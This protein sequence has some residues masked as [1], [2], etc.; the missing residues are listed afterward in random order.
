[1]WKSFQ[2]I[3]SFMPST[4]QI[5][6]DE[7]IRVIKAARR[8][9]AEAL[10]R[11]T[12]ALETGL[13]NPKEWFWKNP[14]PF[15]KDPFH[16]LRGDNLLECCDLE[17][18][19]FWARLLLD[20]KSLI[21]SFFDGINVKW[22]AFALDEI[23][24]GATRRRARDLGLKDSVVF[25]THPE[26]PH[27]KGFKYSISKPFL[28]A[29][30]A[31]LRNG[32]VNARVAKE[33]KV[34]Q[35][36]IGFCV[37]Q[38]KISAQFGQLNFIHVDNEGVDFLTDEGAGDCSAEALRSL[39]RQIRNDTPET[40]L[41]DAYLLGFKHLIEPNARIECHLAAMTLFH[42]LTNHEAHA[43]AHL[44]FGF[45]VPPTRE[46]ALLIYNCLQIALSG[47]PAVYSSMCR[48]RQ[49]AAGL[50]RYKQMVQ[51][52]EP[53]LKRISGVLGQMQS[54][55]QELRAVLY[56]PEE[57]LFA[58]YSLVEPYFRNGSSVRF[59][60][61]AL[62]PI[63]L[64]HSPSLYDTYEVQL[65]AAVVLC[66]V[67]GE[68]KELF[69]QEDRGLVLSKA[70]SIMRRVSSQES[71]A[72]MADDLGWLVGRSDLASFFDGTESDEHNSIKDAC[73]DALT[74]I[75]ATLFTPFKPDSTKWP[76]AALQLLRRHENLKASELAINGRKRP[77]TRAPVATTL[78]DDPDKTFPCSYSSLLT[79]IRDFATAAKASQNSPSV[80]KLDFSANNGKKFVVTLSESPFVNVP[81]LRGNCKQVLVSSRD[82]RIENANYGDM[83]R[84]FVLFANRL[85][86]IGSEWEIGQIHSGQEIIRAVRT[87]TVFSVLWNEKK[88]KLIIQSKAA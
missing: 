27:K 43:A 83:A 10:A 49:E 37:T 19:P 78:M 61:A 84:A 6:S 50:A 22:A 57:A 76:E 23:S 34:E 31:Q 39:V 36:G 24:A 35:K 46:Q 79:F 62:P 13:A 4:S 1:M 9:N 75:K 25:H 67:F 33:A 42:S 21:E 60:K 28:D 81:F 20:S 32:S 45:Q 66:A 73:T 29:R 12:A 64:T 3:I 74:S 15:P 72:R 30:L 14:L 59:Q 65:I 38:R 71:S 68:D 11:L 85:M 47:L 40:D 86:G 69:D 7:T 17:E 2:F 51:L 48:L 16:F 56:E 82:W 63:H 88:H 52:L 70:A 53:P 5:A 18:P 55:T 80:T 8:A 41:W 44:V 77:L 26:E 54:D 58:S 87:G